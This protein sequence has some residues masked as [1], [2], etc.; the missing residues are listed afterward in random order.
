MLRKEPV[1]RLLPK[2]RKVKRASFISSLRTLM[3]SWSRSR[4]LNS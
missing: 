1:P 4:S 2:P 3:T